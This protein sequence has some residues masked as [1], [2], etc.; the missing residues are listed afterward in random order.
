MSRRTRTWILVLLL[1]GLVGGAGVAAVYVLR[2]GL[3]KEGLY[4]K[5]LRAAREGR[6]EEAATLL[7]T[8]IAADPK[9]EAARGQLGRLLLEGRRFAELEALA[10]EWIDTGASPVLGWKLQVESAWNQLRFDEA[11]RRARERADLDPAFAKLV[12][13]HVRDAMGSLWDRLEACKTA[14]SLAAS[15]DSD[16][17]K[18]EMYRFA[19]ETLLDLA[20]L[21]PA[22]RAA[23]AEKEAR[24][25]LDQAEKAIKRARTVREGAHEIALARVQIL[26]DIE[27]VAHEGG[28]TLKRALDSQPGNHEV[29]AALA[30]YHIL[31]EN[32]EEAVRLVGEL[33]AGPYLEWMRAVRRL[34][35]RGRREEVLRLLADAPFPDHPS[36]VLLKAQMLLLGG[37]PEK[38]EAT[39]MLEA[40]V[41]RAGIDRG[42]AVA[43][44][45][46]LA[47]QGRG[48]EALQF[49]EA[50]P[51]GE[52]DVQLDALRALVVGA[53]EQGRDE[54][55][56][57]V[58]EVARK[59]QSI[60]ESIQVLAVLR[61]GGREAVGR[62]LDAKVAAGGEL[63]DEH[64]LVRAMAHALLVIRGA[65]AEGAEEAKASAVA[66]LRALEGLAPSKPDLAA[67][68]NVALALGEHELFGRLTA[69]AT[70]LE[71]PPQN[72][73]LACLARAAGTKEEP[74]R[75]AV[76]KGLREGCP[77]D[78]PSEFLG[79]LADAVERQ[80]PQGEVLAGTDAVAKGASRLPALYLALQMAYLA[81]KSESAEAA[82]RAILE[83][84]PAA[85]DARA[86]LAD[87][88]LRRKAYAEVL[89]LLA[90]LEGAPVLA[91]AQR[92]DA[93]WALERKDEAL[94]VARACLKARTLDAEAYLLLARLHLRQD[95]KDLALGVV[96]MA[97]PT[98]EVNLLH[99]GLLHDRGEKGFAEL[100]Y[101]GVLQRRPAQLEAWWGLHRILMEDG[102]HEQ[103]IQQI[104][105]A[106][107]AFGEREPRLRAELHTMRGMALQEASR[108]DEALADYEKTLE[109][110]GDAAGAIPLNNAAWLILDRHPERLED[111]RK[112]AERALELAP[113]SANIVHTAAMIYRQSKLYDR[114]LE[115]VERAI[116]LKKEGVEDYLFD[117]ACI[118]L[119]LQREAE[120]KDLFERIRDKFA[121]TPAARKSMEK[122]RALRPPSPTPPPTPPGEPPKA[123]GK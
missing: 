117:K 22:E 25:H 4:E 42:I 48:E 115:S 30:H 54:A 51:G 21:F 119:E 106:L 24:R 33:K 52:S 31:R 47:G 13:I 39:R 103:H 53:S 71:G 73:P 120:A 97:P 84:Q 121:G 3:Q 64:R 60:P 75:A 74:V 63:E 23:D 66:D 15:S 114:A 49:L 58:D 112:Y 104:T 36:I 43:A 12:L 113:E 29:R 107:A 37:D 17:V 34:G 90:D 67:A 78:G 70:G 101:Q 62:Y 40:L 76:A 2:R 85:A 83:A 45:R 95:R 41:A 88:L 59:V 7:R 72:L 28:E 94:E 35:V 100:L 6:P 68:A 18:G 10:Q 89:D 16:P 9:N 32:W 1:L 86:A 81:G 87:L 99:A 27:R 109:L 108:P 56:A 118:L 122:L 116:S 50:Q 11:E 80:T 57:I 19:G 8:V 105:Q 26:S 61:Q 65:D 92:A 79:F 5:G 96:D 38:G 110:A 93:L 69:K 111:A 123:E 102:R 98:P 44:Y 20:P 82:A 91:Y 46:L 14:L 55:L 77:K